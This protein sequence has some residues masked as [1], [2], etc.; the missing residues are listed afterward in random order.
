MV[1]L[2]HNTHSAY[3]VRPS[4]SSSSID[5][6]FELHPCGGPEDPRPLDKYLPLLLQSSIAAALLK[7]R[8]IHN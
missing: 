4:S 2:T 5:F 8:S 1:L 7:L 6:L 3:T